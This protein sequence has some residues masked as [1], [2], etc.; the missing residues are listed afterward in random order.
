VKDAASFW[1]RAL[2]DVRLTEADR[3]RDVRKGL[4]ASDTALA[5]EPDDADALTC[6]TLL[7]RLQAALEQDRATQTALLAEAQKLRTKASAL[8]KRNTAGLR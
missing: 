7:L 1:D 2:R 3:R 5:I 4:E 6:K 8:Q